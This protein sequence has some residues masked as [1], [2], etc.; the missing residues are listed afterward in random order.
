ML[1]SAGEGG[2]SAFAARRSG[3]AVEWTRMWAREEGTRLL[4]THL[5]LLWPACARLSGLSALS[6]SKGLSPVA[7]VP[8][9]PRAANLCACATTLGVSKCGSFLFVPL[10]WCVPV[11]A[12]AL[13][14]PLSSLLLLPS[15]PLAVCIII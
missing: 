7:S 12:V 1:V 9:W 3:L 13:A 6:R 4:C 5:C 15:S 14:A 11:V 2:E 10:S 8:V